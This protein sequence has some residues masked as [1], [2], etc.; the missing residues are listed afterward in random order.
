MTNRDIRQSIVFDWCAR[1][2][3]VEH[4]MSVPQR[5]I[6]L[7]EEAVEAYQAAGGDEAT[8]HKLVSF[9]FARPTGELAQELGGVAVTLLALASAAGLS[10]EGEEVREIERVLA[11]SPEHFHARNV[12][13]NAAG[14]DLTGKAY[15]MGSSK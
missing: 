4:A 12:A 8:A 10:A 9:V 11:K 15:P 6:R 13:K 1:C 3:G 14:F 2:F 7:L 5:G